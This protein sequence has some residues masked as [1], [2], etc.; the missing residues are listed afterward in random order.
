M[1]ITSIIMNDMQFCKNKNCKICSESIEN[2]KN[3]AK[4]E[5]PISVTFDP[6]I[7]D[8]KVYYHV[9]TLKQ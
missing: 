2:I 3:L 5:L 6:F 7:M 4:F 9:K 8:N 1:Q